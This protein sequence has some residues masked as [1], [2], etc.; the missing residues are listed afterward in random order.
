MKSDSFR[1]GSRGP[2]VQILSPRPIITSTYS[3]YIGA[4]FVSFLA[5][6]TTGYT[7]M[8]WLD[9]NGKLR[10]WADYLERLKAGMEGK[11]VVIERIRRN[12]G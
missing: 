12:A 8:G 4:F 10:A 9:F 6:Y 2:E 1:F 11:V 5:G 7:Q 3:L